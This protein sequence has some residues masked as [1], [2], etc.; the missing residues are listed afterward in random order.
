[1]FTSIQIKDCI[2][3]IKLEYLPVYYEHNSGDE[4]WETKCNTVDRLNKC[5]FLV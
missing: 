2:K 4:D 5:H 1:L 3:Y